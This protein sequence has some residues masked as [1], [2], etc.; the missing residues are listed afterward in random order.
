MEIR[1]LNAR[2][3]HS[4]FLTACDFIISNRENLNAINLFPVADG[5]TGDNMSATALSVIHHSST[6][7]T[8][9]ETLQSL[10]NSALL[11]ARGNS[12]MIFSQFFNGL[13]ETPIESEE[14]N[15]ITFAQLISK[16]SHSVRSAILHPVEGTII[17]V[18]DAWSASINRLA[19]DLPCFKTLIKQTLTEVNQALQSTTNTLPVLKEAHVVDA[20]ALGFYHFISG[21]ADYLAN[22]R[23][24]DKNHHHLECTEPHHDLPS[25][26]APPDQ[27]Y[28]TEIMLSGDHIDRVTVAQH[29]ERF[30]DCVVSS[31]NTKLA[32]FHLHCN[33]PAEV[34][35]SLLDVGTITQAKA[36]DML[37]QFQMIHDRKYPIALVTDSTADIPQA[38]LDEYQIHMIQLN[39]HL[40]NHHLLDRICVDQNSFYDNLTTLKTYPT[41]SFPSPA[42]LEEQIAQIANHYEQVLVLPISQALSGTHDGIVKASQNFAN[43]HVLN[44]RLTSGGLGFLLTYAAQM[45]A[46]G[47]NI[48]EIKSSIEAKINK[49]ST[50]VFV[51]Q[52]DSLIRCGRINKIGGRIAQFAHLRPII[53]LNDQGKAVIHDKAFSEVKGLSKIVNHVNEQRKDQPLEA[54][55][56][57]HAGAPEKAAEFAKMT[58]EAFGQPPS[59]IEPASTA[60]GLHAGKGCLGL[61]TVFK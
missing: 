25:N 59:F 50:Y 58:T 30:G 49:I 35:S 40:D 27:R 4:A 48:D 39:M 5:D 38:L 55:C 21:F 19:Q 31:G 46:K 60:I 11:G 33:Q 2:T 32:R 1:Y 41:T 44:T 57:V 7:P 17:T 23:E 26:G 14:L 54:Y 18:I 29:L 13:T 42:I 20:G 8:L 52:F 6:K 45:I 43:V 36:Q 10:A 12:G 56:I 61:V 15:T 37:R 9:K 3:I 28:C 16:A 24:I 53:M 47:Q 34:F 51:D 22:P